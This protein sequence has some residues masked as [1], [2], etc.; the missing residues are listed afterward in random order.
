MRK[1]IGKRIGPVPITLVAVA[2][3]GRRSFPLAHAAGAVNANG[4]QAQRNSRK[5]GMMPQTGVCGD[6]RLT[7]VTVIAVINAAGEL[8]GGPVSGWRLYGKY[9]GWRFNFRCGTPTECKCRRA[10]SGRGLYH[11]AVTNTPTLPVCHERHDQR[12]ERRAS[13]K[14]WLN[15]TL[16]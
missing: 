4:I 3:F 5:S 6:R 10:R 15:L 8:M 12:W 2:R 13:T 1:K 9:Y 14:I 11:R 7:T 16:V